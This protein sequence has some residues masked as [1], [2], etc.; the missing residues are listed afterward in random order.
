MYKRQ[1]ETIHGRFAGRFS[2]PELKPKPGDRVCLSIRPESLS[3][4]DTRPAINGIAGRVVESTYLGEIAQYSL[5]PEAGDTI[6]VA[7]LNPEKPR[8]PSELH[9]YA[10]VRPDDVVLLEV[11]TE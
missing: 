3:L 4:V 11:E 10:S 9:I 1:V 8:E 6:R 5:Q 2:N 7:E